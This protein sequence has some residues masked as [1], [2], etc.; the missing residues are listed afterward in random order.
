A[1]AQAALLDRIGAFALDEPYRFTTVPQVV[2]TL[3]PEGLQAAFDSG[4]VGAAQEDTLAAPTLAESTVLIG[5]TSAWSNGYSGAGQTIA[6]LDTGVDKGH[7]FLAGKVISEGCY[8]ST[9]AA[10]G[11]TSV[12]PGGVIESTAPGSGAPCSLV[13]A[14]CEHG[15]HVAGIAAGNGASFSGVARGANLIAIQVFS[16]FDSLTYCG[17]SE[18]CALTFTSDQMKGLE[19]IYTLSSSYNI[20]AVNMSLGGDQYTANCDGD[21]RKPLIDNL[22]AAGVATVIAAGNNG[23]ANALSAPACISSAISVG[24]TGDGSGG[25]IV[26]AVSYFSNSASFLTLLAP[27][28]VITSSV[29]GGGYA[30]LSGTSMAAPHVAGAVALLLSRNPTLSVEAIQAA[31]VNTGVP[32]TLSRNGVTVT[33]ARIRLAQALAALPSPPAL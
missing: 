15:T 26:D 24:S 27:G 23:F 18:P 16:R 8:S 31:L 28:A 2:V 12:C 25:T 32:V 1:S 5:A 3:T 10:Y 22:R 9:D 4:L 29:P 7:A 20:A 6:I 13:I 14:G 21:A 11:A 33:K 17:T 19:R 30:N